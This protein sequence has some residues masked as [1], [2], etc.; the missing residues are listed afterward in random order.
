M[1]LHR[2]RANWRLRSAVAVGVI[3]AAVLLAATTIYTRSLADLG[4]DV[5]LEERFPQGTVL[6]S[7]LPSLPLDGPR[8]AD[9]GA[10]V[11]EG[12]DQRLGDL[13]Q[14]RIRSAVSRPFRVTEPAL[15]ITAST[16][17][18]AVLV[19]VAGY[20]QLVGVRGRLPQPPIVQ[21]DPTALPRIQGPLEVALPAAIAANLGVGLNDRIQFA[22]HFDDCDRE[23]PPAPGAPLPSRPPCAPSVTV[24]TLINAV[25]VGLIDQSDPSAPFWSAAP[26]SFTTTGGTNAFLPIIPLFVSDA[27]MFGP[28]TVVFGGYGMEV[29]WTSLLNPAVLDIPEIGEV[30]RDLDL[31]RQDLRSV[32]GLISGPLEAELARF[33]TDLDFTEVPVLML[34]AQVVGIVLL[35]LVVVGGMV[36]ERNVAEIALL[37]SRGASIGQVVA[38]Y[39]ADGLLVAVLA[40]ALA[41]LLAAGAVA[42]LGLTPQFSD[43]TG[44]SLIAVN[45]RPLAWGL[46]AVGALTA[47]LAVLV[48]LVVAAG[49]RSQEQRRNAARPHT[50]NVLLRSYLDIALALVAAGLIWEA[51]LRG[52]LFTRSSVGGLDPDPLLLATPALFA[53]VSAVVVVRVWPFLLR[54]AARLG[55]DLAA[56]PLLAALRQL[57]RQPGPALRL[58]LLLMLGAA[59]GTFAASFGSTVD[60]SFDERIRYETGVDLR[61]ELDPAAPAEPAAVAATF[62]AVEG[63]HSASAVLRTAAA[64]GLGSRSAH[65]LPLLAIDPDTAAAQLWFREDFASL[66]LAELMR[67]I[68]SP[69]A[70]TGLPVPQ[71]AVGLGLWV[72]P[73]VVRESVTVWLR[74]RDSGGRFFALALGPLP[75]DGGWQPLRG[76][77]VAAAAGARAT[78]PFTLHGI[79]MSELRG[80]TVPETGVIRFDNLTARD[81]QGR[82]TLLDDFEIARPGWNV[83]RARADLPDA[84]VLGQD[85]TAPRGPGVLDFTW[86]LG[87]GA[88]TRGVYLQDPVFCDAGDCRLPVIAATQYL[89]NTGLDVGSRTRVRLGSLILP[90]RITGEAA[91]FPTLDPGGSGFLILNMHDLHA[92]SAVND[93]QPQA[94]PNEVWL[95]GPNDPQAR[96]ALLAT[97]TASP[98][99]CRM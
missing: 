8:A 39:L 92:F 5:A 65:N 67:S 79:L 49:A 88:G 90:I 43:V 32:D 35:Y 24:T 91:L 61:V 98:S 7:F 46:A 96:A 94:T 48:P 14:A 2:L 17:A 9:V 42:L 55:R 1:V 82:E 15:N 18:G 64:T 41:P 62:N 28:L 26:V 27:A 63:A 99:I 78:A 56:I 68:A 45:L 57:L 29:R 10:F 6:R 21:P 38:L 16:P 4:L 60:R 75:R 13:S 89:R 30:R 11:E 51:N 97:L 36:V 59:L 31:L 93:F 81:A 52:S 70:L 12:L 37:R 33:Q 3:I 74:L 40:A 19:S 85:P 83:V 80:G 73:M 72:N 76:D 86:A 44:G 84:A 87:R 77:L 95:A 34:L 69:G 20:E 22:D 23:P 58:I 66:P 50:P 54:L 53:L 25:V 71:D 47:L